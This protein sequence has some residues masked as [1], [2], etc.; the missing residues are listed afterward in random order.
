MNILL[1]VL[2]AMTGDTKLTVSPKM[3]TSGMQGSV[4]T[5]H[6]SL[7]P[8]DSCRGRRFYWPDETTSYHE[9]DCDPEATLER[10]SETMRRRFGPGEYQVCVGLEQ[11]EG[12]TIKRVC[13][14]F[15]VM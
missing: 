13:D 4:V 9:V 15:Q 8:E 7:S 10:D 3:S 6:L 2:L 1:I 5:F 14:T 12:K 11:P